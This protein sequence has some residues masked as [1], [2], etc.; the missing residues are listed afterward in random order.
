MSHLPQ[1]NKIV[2]FFERR[3]QIEFG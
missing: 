1:R 2:L 3:L